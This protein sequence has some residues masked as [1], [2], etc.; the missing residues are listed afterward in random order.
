MDKQRS[1]RLPPHHRFPLLI[2]LIGLLVCAAIYIPGLSGPWL[3]DDEANLE[4]FTRFAQGQAP[5]SDI[6]LSNHS[7]PLGRAVS[8]ATFAGNHALGLFSSPALKTTNLIIHL[9]NC[10]LIFFLLSQLFRRRAPALTSN[11]LASCLAI[12]WLLLPLHISTVL[13]IVQRMT[14][15]STFFSLSACLSYVMGRELLTMYPL[16]SKLILS[17]SL[18]LLLPLAVFAKESG[19]SAIAFIVL[20]E[21]FFFTA[22]STTPRRMLPLLSGIIAF[23]IFVGTVVAITP[24]QTF[25]E[26]YLSRNFSLG[27]RLLTQPRVIFSYV[28]DI[29][30]PNSSH[31]GLYQDDFIIS[32]SLFSPLTTVPALLGLAILLLVA[33]RCADSPRWWPTSFGL[34]F[35]FSGHLVESTLIP[36]ELYFEHRNYLPSVGLLIAV[37]PLITLWPW[38]L[39]LLTLAFAAYLA[40]LALSAFQRTAIWGNQALLLQTSALNHPLS[41]RAGTDYVESLLAQRQVGQALATTLRGAEKSPDFAAIYYL[42]AISIYCRVGDPPPAILIQHAADAMSTLG[43]HPTS[44]NIGLDY[45]LKRK[46]T[47]HCGHANF[48][49]LVM[50]LP[51]VD[52]RLVQ[53]YGAMRRVVWLTRFTISQ[54]LADNGQNAQA[55]IILDDIWSQNE[56]ADMPTIGLLLAKTLAKENESARLQQVLKEL[57]TVTRDAPAEFIQEMNALKKLATG[58]Q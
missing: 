11:L 25:S 16:R 58:Q 34:L 24:P 41:T 52:A 1:T 37:T 55:L 20:I 27:E 31:M 53:R 43:N 35:Y 32:H 47:G 48:Q 9:L 8:M 38:R 33:L 45:V 7:G 4:G 54:W 42:Q 12:W 15:V 56:H 30:L 49:P 23:I 51:A 46:Q 14:Q 44:L 39:R 22:I 50:A 21:L 26:A 19:I 13:Y 6:I 18:L 29:F 28:R 5:Y 40:L 36:L 2:M 57:D 17:S 3:V 10:L